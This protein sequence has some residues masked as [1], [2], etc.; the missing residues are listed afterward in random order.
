MIIKYKQKKP[1]IDKNVLNYL[2]THSHKDTFLT[3]IHSTL[4][5]YEFMH[6]NTD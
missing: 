5:N 3:I 2:T 6:K 4:L 1:K